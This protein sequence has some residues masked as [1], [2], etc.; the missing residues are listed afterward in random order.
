MYHDAYDC[1]CITESWLHSSICD[2]A[3]DPR[4]EYL[5]VR[6]DRSGNKGGGVCILVKRSISVAPLELDPRYAALEIAGVEFI[7]SRAKLQL[8]Y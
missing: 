2:G 6:K 1:I 5:I 4:K 3:I 7:C 8:R